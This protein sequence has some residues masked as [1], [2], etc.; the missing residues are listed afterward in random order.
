MKVCQSSSVRCHSHCMRL[1]TWIAHILRKYKWICLTASVSEKIEWRMIEWVTVKSKRAHPPNHSTP[2]EHLRV[3]L[4]IAGHKI[5]LR[6]KNEVMSFWDYFSSPHS[7]HRRLCQ[8][9]LPTNLHENR[10]SLIKQCSVCLVYDSKW[11][12]KR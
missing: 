12:S 2:A 10:L 11:E 6:I 4:P 9:F 3:S 7:L 1:E 8:L 5:I